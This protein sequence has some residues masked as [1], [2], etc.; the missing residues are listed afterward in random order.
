MTTLII[1]LAVTFAITLAIILVAALVYK[2]GKHDPFQRPPFTDDPNA[3][4]DV[5]PEAWPSTGQTIAQLQQAR[6]SECGAIL[7][8]EHAAGCRWFVE[9]LRGMQNADWD[10]SKQRAAAINAAYDKEFTR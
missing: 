7:A 9:R 4:L 6:C 10:E 2:P 8:G 3:Y 5:P 1:I